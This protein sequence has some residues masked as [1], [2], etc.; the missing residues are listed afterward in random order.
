MARI[1]VM[2]K[3]QILDLSWMKILIQS[4]KQLQMKKITY[5]QSKLF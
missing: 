4:I 2:K 3:K 1:T 5:G